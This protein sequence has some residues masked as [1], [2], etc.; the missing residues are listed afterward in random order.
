MPLGCLGSPFPQI[1][2]YPDIKPSPFPRTDPSL[3]RR[4]FA[5]SIFPGFQR[6]SPELPSFVP[7]EFTEPFPL[8]PRLIRAGVLNARS[9]QTGEGDLRRSLNQDQAH[10]CGA[11]LTQAYGDRSWNTM[12]STSFI[13][14]HNYTLRRTTLY[15]RSNAQASKSNK[16]WVYVGFFCID[17]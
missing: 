10:Q 13:A 14:L 7:D 4:T 3:P 15:T 17:L 5:E 12:Q 8:I 2:S 16:Y 1:K 9:I 11:I 6:T